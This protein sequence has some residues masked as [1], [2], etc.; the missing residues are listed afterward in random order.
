MSSLRRP[1]KSLGQNFLVDRN[2]IDK[3][4]ASAS[5]SADDNILEIG[6][7]R[8]A[9]TEIMA[10]RAARL[11]L[12][13]YDH[14]LAAGLKESHAADNRITVV[15]ADVLAVNLAELMG[16]DVKKWKVV[17]NL[18][19]NIST[20]VLFRLL[21]VRHKVSRMVLMLQRE[22]AERLTAAPDCSD[23]GV[24]T[25]LLG[26]WYDMRIEFIVPPGC[27]HPRPK[28]DSAVISFVPLDG[29]RADVGNED[30]FRRIVKAAFAM[31]RKTLS[32]CLKR[33]ELPQSEKLDSVLDKCGID[34]R[35][36]GETLSLDEFAALSR[37]FSGL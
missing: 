11:L 34:G 26:L 25:V 13:E 23:Y 15:D 12:I 2:I 7:G 18:P 14:A 30:I 28:V 19:Y 20:Q 32:N 22:V 24:T 33:A 8:G 5:L 29:P 35:R 16:E 21:E 37:H 27:F 31:R 1:L 9:L 17:A 4:I 36:R 10:P 3:I 6:P